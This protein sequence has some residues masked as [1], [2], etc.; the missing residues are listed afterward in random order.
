LNFSFATQIFSGLSGM[1]NVMNQGPYPHESAFDPSAPDHLIDV[2]IGEQ[3]IP[4]R[5]ATPEERAKMVRDQ[6]PDFTVAE[7]MQK[8]RDFREKVIREIHD[9]WPWL[10]FGETWLPHD[11]QFDSPYFFDFLKKR[12]YATYHEA[13]M[14]GYVPRVKDIVL[15]D[16]EFV[17]RIGVFRAN[18]RMIAGLREGKTNEGAPLVMGDSSRGYKRVGL[19]EFQPIGP[20]QVERLKADG[21]LQRRLA[22]GTMFEA[23]SGIYVGLVEVYAHPEIAAH[24]KKAIADPYIRMMADWKRRTRKPSSTRGLFDFIWRKAGL[25]KAGA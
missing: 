12:K 17:G 7:G 21:S 19:R 10:D 16:S 13:Q 24:L 22:S 11:Y 4:R 25:G 15:L 9:E 3:E 18:Q 2:G 8:Y 5:L 6:D 1:L 20:E 23:Q 14:D